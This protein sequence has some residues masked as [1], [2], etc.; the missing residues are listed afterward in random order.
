MQI[1]VTGF[2]PFGGEATNPSMELVK[3]L[4]PQI[5]AAHI[6]TA[7][8]PVTASGGLQAALRAIEEIGPDAV[9]CVG[10]AGGRCAVTV[11]RVAVNVDDFSIPDN[12]GQQPR[13]LPIVEG[14]PDAYLSTLPIEKMVEAMRGAGVPAAV[15]NSAGTYVCN[16]VM[17]GVAHYL[18]QHRPGAV[19][20]FI[21]IPYLPQQVLDKPDKA[22]MGL[23]L[24]LR[25]LT[26]GLEVLAAAQ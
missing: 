1:L 9:V 20:G 25:G 23:E 24:A 15:S 18:A 12:E 17:Y 13:N 14:G 7:I 11:E 21:H 10:Q 4:E 5:G 8:L 22:S 19:S 3:A 6:H 16:H 26:A 2:E